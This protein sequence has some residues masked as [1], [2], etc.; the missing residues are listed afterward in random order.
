M[1]T[2]ENILQ[3]N[4]LLETLN[5]V[6]MILGDVTLK[7]LKS[8]I[9]VDLS[10]LTDILMIKSNVTTKFSC[11]LKCVHHRSTVQGT[12]IYCKSLGY[13]NLLASYRTQV[14]EHTSDETSYKAVDPGYFLEQGF[15][16]THDNKI[17]Y[18]TGGAVKK[19]K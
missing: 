16:N 13:K 5:V 3:N 14:Q 12:T 17:E 2:A 11:S 10:R 8:P 6:L 15:L 19:I 9:P 4:E 7:C 1:D 18:I